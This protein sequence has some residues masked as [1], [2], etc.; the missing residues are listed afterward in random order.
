MEN[1]NYTESYD[2]WLEKV[3]NTSEIPTFV[4]EVK[5]NCLLDC[6]KNISSYFLAPCC[7]INGKMHMAQTYTFN[8]IEEIEQLILDRPSFKLFKCIKSIRDDKV[9]YFLR[10]SLR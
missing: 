6:F 3:G 4:N 2:I 10:G 8:T 9:Q 5:E 7:M 1:T